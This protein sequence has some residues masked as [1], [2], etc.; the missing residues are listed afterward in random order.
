MPVRFIPIL[1]CP[2]GARRR[3]ADRAPL[4]PVRDPQ[5]HGPPRERRCAGPL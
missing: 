4:P 3:T 1:R 2:A 5:R